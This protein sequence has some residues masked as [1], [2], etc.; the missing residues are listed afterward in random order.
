MVVETETNDINPV[1]ENNSTHMNG[2]VEPTSYINQPSQPTPCMYDLVYQ[3]FHQLTTL[4][5]KKNPL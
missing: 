5:L 1:V 3:E 2:N 4:L